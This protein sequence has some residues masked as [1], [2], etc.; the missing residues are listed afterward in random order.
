V[1][2]RRKVLLVNN[3]LGNGGLERQLVLLAE[4]LPETWDVRLW[5]MEGGPYADR[6]RELGVPWICS[7][8]RAR[9]DVSPAA[10]LW[11]AM[12]AWRPDVVHAWHWMP[13]LAAAPACR[14]CGIPLID[15]SIR[16]GSVPRDLGRPRR[17]IMRLATLVVA[18]SQAGLDAWRIGDDKGRVIYNGFDDVRLRA[19]GPAPQRLGGGA[20]RFTVV[21]AARMRPQ[22]D[23]HA[24]IRAARE[25]ARASPGEWSF[26]IVGDGPDRAALETAARDLVASGVVEFRRPGL[27]AITAINAAQVG[28]LM[29]D[30]AV[31]TEGCSNTILEYMACGLPVVCSDTGGCSEL[32]RDGAEGYLIAPYDDV[33]LAARLAL[34]R[35][36]PSRRE[37]MGAAGRARVRT[38]FSVPRMVDAYLS[39]Y[40]EAAE[41]RR[42]DR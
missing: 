23:F 17:S 19:A 27:E 9:F 34:L 26:L 4:R 41:R 20:E 29:T 39:V 8:R 37:R 2:A 22:K 16:M 36:D 15:G 32:V 38:D 30:P 42:R 31:L 28:V 40:E 21:M 1:P 18:N 7:P 24:V 12:R 10:A 25:L 11:R 6:V 13:A 35:A 33:A 14:L 3:G 5:T